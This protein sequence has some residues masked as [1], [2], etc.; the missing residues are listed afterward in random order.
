MNI[1]KYLTLVALATA[2]L[3]TSA[4]K[5]ETP[6]PPPPAPA[7][8]PLFS[9]GALIGLATP[10]NR[11][12]DQVPTLG[13]TSLSIGFQPGRFGVW[14]DFDALSN[15]EASHDTL[16]A[17]IGIT[18]RPTQHLMLGARSGLG[19][20]LVNF[21]DPAFRDVAAEAVL[22]FHHHDGANQLGD[23]P[24]GT[25]GVSYS[26]YTGYTPVNEPM[27]LRLPF[28]PT[29]VHDPSSWQPLRYVDGSGNLVTP[30]FLGPQWPRVTT[31]AVSPGF[32]RSP[33]GPAEY[34]SA[35]YLDQA[36]A[37]LDL[38]AGLTDEQKMIAEYWAA[39]ANRPWRNTTRPRVLE[40]TA[41]RSGSPS[42]SATCRACRK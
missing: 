15:S 26:D 31:F 18:L 17:S 8:R 37:L 1:V 9:V 36:R 10:L 34:G 33:T 22:D 23:E 20:T 32:L 27:D 38:S 21:K 39:C 14:L 25:P 16:L 5:K 42:A 24:G 2:A 19:L 12:A 28:D 30:G 3:G 4:C 40:E 6:P 13:G 41:R 35:Q 29:A 11:R 7:G